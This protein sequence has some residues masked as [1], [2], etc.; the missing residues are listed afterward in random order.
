MGGSSETEGRVWKLQAGDNKK[1]SY[2]EISLSMDT[3]RSRVHNLCETEA[4]YTTEED[5][6]AF[7][8]EESLI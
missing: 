1:K 5:T 7:G 8:Q 6:M 4:A 2:G 3:K